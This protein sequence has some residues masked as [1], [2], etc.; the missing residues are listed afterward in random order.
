MLSGAIAR[1]AHLMRLTVVDATNSFPVDRFLS[2]TPACEE[3]DIN[4][5]CKFVWSYFQA[6][7]SNA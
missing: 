6:I 1:N 3:L 2:N 5:S 7:A 4:F